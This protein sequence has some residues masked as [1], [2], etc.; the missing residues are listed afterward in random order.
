MLDIMYFKQIF[1][2]KLA[3]TGSFDE[4]FMKAIW[5]AFNYGVKVGEEAKQLESQKKDVV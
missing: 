2:E 4:S 3:K 5:A 1:N